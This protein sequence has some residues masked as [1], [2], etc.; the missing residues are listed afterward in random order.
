M[1]FGFGHTHTPEYHDLAQVCKCEPYENPREISSEM[2]VRNDA[3]N[4]SPKIVCNGLYRHENRSRNTSCE[5]IHF[6]R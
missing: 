2:G 5:K 1:S 3:D 4:S 6:S